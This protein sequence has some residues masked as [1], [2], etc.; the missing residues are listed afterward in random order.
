LSTNIILYKTNYMH[1]VLLVSLLFAFFIAAAN[2]S[3]GDYAGTSCETCTS[4]SFLGIG[5]SWDPV[6][7]R[8]CSVCP[9]PA[10]KQCGA[11]CG[12]CY[13]QFNGQ[14]VT[15]ASGCSINIINNS[16]V[17]GN[18]SPCIPCNRDD[19]SAPLARS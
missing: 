15:C 17:C 2:A 1:S 12:S 16:C 5:C 7:Q 13:G 6:K 4:H 19:T 3:C 8:C 9:Y 14:W 10:T 18:G 11:S